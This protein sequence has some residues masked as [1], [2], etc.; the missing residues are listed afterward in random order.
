[1]MRT[2]LGF[3]PLLAAGALAA[4]ASTAWACETPNSSGKAASAIP[5]CCAKAAAPCQATSAAETAVVPVAG[6]AG[7]RAFI[8]PETG[9]LGGMPPAGEV[10]GVLVEPPVLV[11]EY[12]PDGSV[13]VDLKG[14]GEHY[15]IMELDADGN[16]VLRCTDEPNKPAPA[17]VAKPGVK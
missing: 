10:E 3:R 8:D 1:M 13:M 5:A 6:E 14:T 7:M 11:Q 2:A 16:R 15:M 17:P 12:L 4:T 9:T